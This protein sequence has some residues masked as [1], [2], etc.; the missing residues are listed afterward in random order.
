[1][2][3]LINMFTVQQIALA[4]GGRIIGP[5][6]RSVSGVATDSRT[7]KSGELFVAL[8]GKNFDGHRF[9]N[10]LTQKNVQVLLAEERFLKNSYIPADVSCIAVKN[11]LYAL[12]ELAASYRQRFDLPV[13][14][15]TG[16]NGKTTTKEM[17]ATVLSQ[18]SFGLKT[19]GNL[20]NQIGLPQTIF[21]LNGDHRWAVLEMGMSEQGEIDRLAEIASPTIGLLLNAFPAHLASMGTVDAIAR[22]KGELLQRIQ[23]NGLAVVNADDPRIISLTQNSSARRISF[24][25]RRGEV[26]AENINGN[27]LDGVSFNLVT[28]KGMIPVKLAAYGNHFIYNAL[29]TAAALLDLL[30]LEEIKNGLAAFRPC[31]GRFCPE[32]VGQLWLIDDSYNANP[33]SCSAALATLSELKQGHKAFVVLGDMLELGN[34]EI[35]LHRR[36]GAQAAA[37]AD[38][39]YLMGELTQNTAKTATTTGMSATNIMQMES[40]TDIARDIL[41]KAVDGDFILIKGSRGMKMEQVAEEIR[42]ISRQEH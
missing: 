5:Q 14:A 26:R 8:R 25:I 6:D 22:A 3:S 9:I 12:G 38:H 35:E 28:P 41:N 18:H 34:E 39:L 23:A 21:R 30:S 15:V 17:L 31:A 20:N 33:A 2:E 40:C 10:D 11:S 32:R 13:I 7:I 42:R 36:L 19:E 37:V 4:T 24:G 27:Q 29:A 16:S 1:M